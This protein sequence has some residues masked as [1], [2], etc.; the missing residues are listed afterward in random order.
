MRINETAKR[1]LGIGL[2]ISAIV[3]V[4]DLVTKQWMLGLLFETPRR[5]E[6]TSFFNLVP[7]WNRGVSF[8]L[9]ASD[10]PW[11]PYL[12]A[13]MA[14]AISGALTIWLA[15]AERPLTRLALALVIG[16]AVGN[17]VDRLRFG[18]VV[19]FL[20]FHL[21]AYHWP[22]F[23]IADSAISVGVVVLLIESFRDGRRKKPLAKP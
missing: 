6:V 15:R 14:L 8:G 3:F 23:N 16:G 17:F 2:M 19:D 21:G 4:A 5:I 7:V 20:D 22:A 9:L 1:R 13:G 12:L 10:S 11:T 18:A